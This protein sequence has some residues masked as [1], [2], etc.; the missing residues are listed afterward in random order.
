MWGVQ[1]RYFQRS[2]MKRTTT[3]STRTFITEDFLLHNN[4]ARVRRAGFRAEVS[5]ELADFH[6]FYDQMYVPFIRSR[7]GAESVVSHRAR[8]ERCFRQGGIVWALDQGRRVAGV[9][10]RQRG[11]TLDFVV[12]G[13]AGG[14]PEPARTGA[15]FAIDLFALEHAR[16]LG[17]TM[18]DFGGSRASP[19][20]GLL[21][22]K[23][24]WGA[25]VLANRTTFYDLCLSWRRLTPPLLALLAHT[26]L[27]FRQADGLAAL[28]SL[29][30]ASNDAPPEMAAAAAVLRSLR[31]IY[32]LG[33]T[34][35][36]A[37]ILPIPSV[38]IDPAAQPS[39]HP[40]RDAAG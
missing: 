4:V 37:P 22:Y 18:V 11:T 5:H 15:V 32:L 31:R 2:T 33:G 10:V 13:T 1:G 35:G 25:R 24:R 3:K 17:C 8:L 26:P 30:G 12:V 6:A 16:A 38:R 34:D 27:I 14:T 20:D 9:L 29:V 39:W 28:W 7:Y 21:L 36:D 23:A 19:S 40:P